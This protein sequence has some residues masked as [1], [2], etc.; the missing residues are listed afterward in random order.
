MRIEEIYQKQMSFKMTALKSKKKLVEVLCTNCD[1]KICL[2]CGGDGILGTV[3]IDN[4]EQ[5]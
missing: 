3:E 2:K 1:S 4:C 5:K